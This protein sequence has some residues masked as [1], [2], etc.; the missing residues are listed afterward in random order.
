MSTWSGRLKELLTGTQEPRKNLSS[1]STVNLKEVKT[2]EIDGEDSIRSVA[3]LVG[4]SHVV[5]GGVEG[6]IRRWRVKDGKEAGT[7][8]NARA[9]VS[10]IAVSPDGKWVVGGTNCG[11]TTVWNAKSGEEAKVFTAHNEWV[12][13]VDVSPD[14]TRIATGSYD[15]DVYIW[16]LPTQDEQQ[17]DRLLGPLRHSWSLA[18]VRFSPD[19]HLIATAT[20]CR[21]S[22]RI[23]DSQNGRLLVEFP[24][25][26][27]SSENQSLAWASDSKQLFALSRD[28]NI[29][30]LDV[31]N[32]TMLSQWPIHSPT[33]TRCIALACNGRLIAAS[34]GSS[35]SFWDTTTQKQ[36]GS[37][38]EHPALVASMA[39][40]ANHDIAIGG[41]KNVT[42]RNI[43]DMLPSSYYEDVS[44][45][46]PLLRW[47]SSNGKLL[48]YLRQLSPKRPSA[49]QRLKMLI[50]GGSS[51]HF[52]YTTTTQ[53]CFDWYT[54][55]HFI[56]THIH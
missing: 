5:T 26:V 24:V 14:A 20:W 30:C 28:G 1:S 52:I 55:S 33:D 42:L 6:Q 13:A 23:Y 53:V 7:P 12:R 2:I 34:A 18:A 38:I 44:C 45:I 36:I 4:G 32:G 46:K 22:V 9:T 3:L 10:N 50:S 40:S 11:L 56:E 54:D 15:R 35:V 49:P 37:V 19:G 16:S 43:C 21:S 31:H 29:N 8:V 47:I 48:C 25:Q 39:I 17:L 51:N 41:G 27:T